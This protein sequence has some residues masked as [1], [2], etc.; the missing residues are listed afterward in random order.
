MVF[1]DVLSAQR[2]SKAIMAPATCRSC[3]TTEIAT[4]AS[5]L[6]DEPNGA[7]MGK[8]PKNAKNRKK[9]AS[10][11]TGNKRARDIGYPRLPPLRAS[12]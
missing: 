12:R 7:W 9:C 11:P 10:A 3:G 5:L 6:W 2:I 1:C 8:T 4:F